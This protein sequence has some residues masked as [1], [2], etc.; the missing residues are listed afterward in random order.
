MKRILLSVCIVSIFLLNT[1]LVGSSFIDDPVQ[2]IEQTVTFSPI[3]F[4]DSGEFITVSCNDASSSIGHVG[5]PEL[6]IISQVFTLPLGSTIDDISVSYQDPYQIHLTKKIIPS[7]AVQYISTEIQEPRFDREMNKLVYESSIQFPSNAWSYRSGA[8]LLGKDNVIYVTV[9]LYPVTYEPMIDTVTLYSEASLSITYTLP[10]NPIVFDDVYDLLI[11][12]PEYYA[13]P[14]Q[15]LVDAKIAREVRTKLTTL[16]DIP[17]VGID[18][19][20]DIK[21]YIRDALENW[22]I[23]YVLLVGG[24]IKE[25]EQIPVRYAWVPSGNYERNFPSDLYYADVLAADGSFPTWDNNSNGRYAEYPKDNDAVDLYPDVYLGRLPCNSTADVEVVVNKIISFMETNKVTKR[26]LQMGGDTFPGDPQ[27]VNE[28]EFANAEVMKRIPDYTAT[29]LWGSKKNL[30]RFN[31]IFNILKG[32]DFVDF[33]GHGSY[34]SWATHPPNDDSKWIPKGLFYDG[35]VYINAQWLFNMNKLSV[36]IFNA[37]S[38][39]KFSEF[40]P[41][42]SWSVIKQP[43]GGAIASY[44]A[45]GIGYGSYG[46][47]ET[48]RVF[49]WMEVNLIDGLAHDKILGSVWGTALN[50]YINSFELDDADYKTIYELAL[51]GD[52]SLAIDNA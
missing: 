37:C 13:A 29:Q 26:I 52:P 6:P 1:V 15:P 4:S 51:F 16:E 38:C 50:N 39:S 14:L 5:N 21:Y 44:G 32:Y 27:N 40:D 25:H 23:T 31:I 9:F 8:G 48:E 47:S 18:R 17:L 2:T 12:A 49:G 46:T 28:G 33:S 11:I 19:Q 10:K 3:D 34:V 36:F 41:C 45:S 42:L 35:F 22:G 43:Y 24:G 7:M 30:F 20:E